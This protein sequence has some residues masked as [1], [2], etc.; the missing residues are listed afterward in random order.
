MCLDILTFVMTQYFLSRQCVIKGCVSLNPSRKRD[1]RRKFKTNRAIIIFCRDT[2]LHNSPLILTRIKRARRW[3][4]LRCEHHSADEAD[5]VPYTI[6]SAPR[7]QAIRAW[8]GRCCCTTCRTEE[9]QATRLEGCKGTAAHA[10]PRESHAPTPPC[11]T[12]PLPPS[13]TRSSVAPWWRAP[14]R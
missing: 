12:L 1:I 8:R 9:Q 6:A 10:G 14:G 5:P 7:M 2:H 13:P 3:N 11:A 4:S